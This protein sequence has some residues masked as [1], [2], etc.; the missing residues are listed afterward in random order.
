MGSFSE[1]SREL[2]IPKSTIS[3]KIA[4]LEEHLDVR[5][6]QRNTR[7]VQLTEV[8][9][10]I[11]NRANN[12]IKEAHSVTATVESA[13]E[14]VA[15]SLKVIAPVSF[16]AE[17]LAALC[18]GFLKLHPKVDLELQYS[19]ND[20][21]IV[22]LNFDIAIK[23]GPLA[24]SNLIAKL[25]F[26]RSRVLVASPDYIEQYDQPTDSRQLQQHAA[27]MLG[28]SKSAPIWPLG[29]GEQRRLVSLKP[30]F[31]ANS[32]ASLK[33]MATAGLGIALITEAEC[34]PELDS[35]ALVRLL[36]DIPIDPIRC[37]GLYTSR[38]Q[39]APKIAH[40]L[41]YIARHANQ[42]QLASPRL[43]LVDQ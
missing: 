15:G 32:V 30:R 33:Q 1:A 11:F 10:A 3:R 2:S 20:A 37:Y 28:N 25:L 43:F 5:L 41:E 31:W 19:D 18:A 9:R 34:K 8:G 23:F 26:E 17:S 40:F 21:D 38:M 35:G 42:Q 12:I 39:L 7:Q 14:D 16:N 29:T 22:G 24:D 36:P 13:R 6:L 4:Q 27:L